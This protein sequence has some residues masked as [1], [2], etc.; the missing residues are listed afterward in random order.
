MLPPEKKTHE[1]P[2]PF[3]SLALY[4]KPDHAVVMLLT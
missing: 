2:K 1:R 4:I 3:M